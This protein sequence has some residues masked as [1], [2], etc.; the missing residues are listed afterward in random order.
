[1]VRTHCVGPDGCGKWVRSDRELLSDL[2]SLA[3]A[4]GHAAPWGW[5]RPVWLKGWGA[6]PGSSQHLGKG[7]ACRD[8][9]SWGMQEPLPCVCVPRGWRLLPA[10]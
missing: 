3:R 9:L 4:A 7:R 5:Y 6:C 8:Q 1:M 2:F 10:G